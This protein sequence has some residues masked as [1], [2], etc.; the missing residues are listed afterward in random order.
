MNVLGGNV[1]EEKINL[2]LMKLQYQYN[3]RNIL[4][5]SLG[6]EVEYPLYLD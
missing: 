1:A 3:Y 4:A 6:W 5:G 2:I